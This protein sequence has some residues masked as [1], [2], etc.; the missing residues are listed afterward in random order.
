MQANGNGAMAVGPTPAGHQ[1]ELNII[2]GM[3]EELSRQLAE[4]RRVTEDIVSSLGRVRNRA[5][6]RGLSNDD[7]LDEAAA[8]IFCV[9]PSLVPCSSGR[10]PS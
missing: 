9:L 4:N 1:A 2:Y 10:A 8:E 7:V 3:V 5:R 6:E